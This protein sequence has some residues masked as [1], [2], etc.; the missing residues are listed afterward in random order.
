MVASYASSMKFMSGEPFM[1]IS[2]MYSDALA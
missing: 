2:M 1:S